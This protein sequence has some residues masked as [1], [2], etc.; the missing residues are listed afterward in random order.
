MRPKT[1]ERCGFAAFPLRMTR[2]VEGVPILACEDCALDL[3]CQRAHATGT[4]CPKHGEP[5]A[6]ERQGAA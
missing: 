2:R 3:E 6:A 1:C 4:Y 5:K